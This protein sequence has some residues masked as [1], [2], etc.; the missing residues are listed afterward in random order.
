MT[1]LVEQVRD[2]FITIGAERGD[3]N[4]ELGKALFYSIKKD[5][6]YR[7]VG[8]AGDVYEGLE[9]LPLH[10]SLSDTD[11]AIAVE[12]TG[13]CAP[14]DDSKSDDDQI[15]PSQHPERRR[16]RLMSLVTRTYN[17][18]SAMGFA[19]EDEV[20]TDDGSARGTLAEALLDTMKVLVS[21]TN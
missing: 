19:D 12:T 16:V 2:L 13:W 6:T 1:T 7:L 10:V 15:L 21:K 17:S 9:N 14:I 20:I 4:K 11:A 3:E 8:A 5:G 18:A